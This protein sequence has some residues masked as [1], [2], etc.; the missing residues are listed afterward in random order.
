MLIFFIWAT[1]TVRGKRYRWWLSTRRSTSPRSSGAFKVGTKY[2]TNHRKKTPS[3]I[4]CRRMCTTSPIFLSLSSSRRPTLCR[5]AMSG[6]S[7][8]PVADAHTKSEERCS[9]FDTTLFEFRLDAIQCASPCLSF[10]RERDDSSQLNI[11]LGSAM[12]PFRAKYFS[13]SSQNAL[14][15]GSIFS[16]SP[17]FSGRL[18]TFLYLS[19]K[20]RSQVSLG[21]LGNTS[22]FNHAR[23]SER[24]LRGTFLPSS[25]H[26]PRS[27]ATSSSTSSDRRGGLPRVRATRSSLASSTREMTRRCSA[28]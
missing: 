7:T 28:S 22:G 2:L 13:S 12:P 15:V 26:V 5:I 9:R 3:S 6:R 10:T 11:K 24:R 16:R 4:P 19:I 20:W 25:E 18:M 27:L 8:W 17:G 23:K 14:N 1:N 21:P